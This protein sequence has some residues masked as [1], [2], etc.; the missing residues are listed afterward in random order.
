MELR[1]DEWDDIS[2]SEL[3]HIEIDPHCSDHPPQPSCSGTVTRKD[4]PSSP[5][6]LHRTEECLD[7]RIIERDEERGEKRKRNSEGGHSPLLRFMKRHLSV[8]QLCEQT[9]CEM[10]V[11]YGFRK[12][13]IRKT[14]KQRTEVQTG[15]KI[16]LARELEVH[17]VVPLHAQSREDSFAIRLL[18]IL[19][20]IPKLEA[21]KCVREIPVF[22]VVEGVHLKGV[23]DE[24]SYNQK[25]ELV[26]NELKTRRQETLPGAAQS[27]GHSLQVG[28]YKILFDGMVRGGLRREHIID[29]FKLKASMALGNEIQKHSAKIGIQVTT[30][31]ELVDT[32]LMVLS[33]T[34]V[35]RIDLLQ[36]EYRH[37]DSNNL[38][39][40]RVVPYDEAQLR[41]ELQGYLAYW[42]GQREPRGV[43]I[44]EAWKCRMCP[45]DQICVW[46][47]NR[48]QA[49]EILHTN[50]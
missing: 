19:H 27:L 38:I 22:G 31:G 48:S 47:K 16:H 49:P 24:L 37:Q 13:Q 44:E 33:C 2:D 30:L 14:E 46:R 9:W 29:H 28:L 8:T 21:G 20:M 26:L 11:E 4:I 45:Y 6:S 43:D 39:G 17:T 5:S 34:D 41:S 25:G 36:I 10:K 50:K 40:S 35:P 1:N 12:P 23:I 3:L 32:L 42:T 15:A 18:N 7:K